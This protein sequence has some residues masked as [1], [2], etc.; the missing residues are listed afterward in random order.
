MRERQNTMKK[1]LLVFTVILLIL[2]VSASAYAYQY[3]KGE[4]VMDLS[5]FDYSYKYAC[6][7][8]NNQ[9]GAVGYREGGVFSA[10]YAYAN[11]ATAVP[12]PDSMILLGLGLLVV[13]GLGRKRLIKG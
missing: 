10:E 13:A 3:A 12:E 7:T 1:V 11:E 6:D 4:A 2:G 9:K 5:S 8:D